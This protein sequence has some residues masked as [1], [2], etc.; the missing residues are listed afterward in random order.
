MKRALVAATLVSTAAFAS[1]ALFPPGNL[2]IW[3]R[4]ASAPQGLYW[5]SGGPLDYD[6]WAVVSGGAPTS[7]WIAEHNYLA[8]G[9]PVIKRVRGL[10]GDEICRLNG[11]V[12]IN[13]KEVATALKKDSSGGELPVWRGCFVLS[14]GEVFL[15]NDHPRSLDGR[16]FGATDID[17]VTGVARLLIKAD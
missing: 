8:R 4:T 6:E 9:W 11:A 10:S 1:I 16:Y 3:N 13:G 15:L 2:L 5:R 7:I 14:D 17:D 12:S